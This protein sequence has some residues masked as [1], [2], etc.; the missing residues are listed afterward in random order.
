MPVQV[1]TPYKE[2]TANGVTTVFPLEFDC[3]KSE[4][5][6]VSLDGNEASVGS[7]TLSG[8]SVVFNTAPANGVIVLLQRN[9]PY[10][11]TTNYQSYD[12]SFRPSPVNK[13]FDLIWWKLQELGVAD[14]ILGNRINALKNYVDERDDELRAYLMEEIRKQGVAL[15]QLEE[16]YNY[17][18]ER[19]A[20]I[21]V[22]RGW[23]S[24][25]V[26]HRGKT[27]YEIN[28]QNTRG[29]KNIDEL[30]EFT[31]S[32][33]SQRV[34]TLEYHPGSG[35]GGALYIWDSA[36]NEDDDGCFIIAVS[37]V[38]TGRWKLQ[39]LNRTLHATQAGLIANL[40]QTD[41][42]NQSSIVQK[43][44][45]HIAKI[46]GGIVKLP[47]GHIYA[48]VLAKSNV[49]IQGTFESF[50]TNK[51]YAEISANPTGVVQ[52]I[53]YEHGT[54]WHSTGSTDLF[55]M[56]ENVS[57]CRISNLKMLGLR[58][59][60]SESACGFGMRIIGD[61]FSAKY[62]DTSGFRFEGL[63]IRGK[64]GVDC[65]NHY[66]E[67]CNFDDARRNTAALVFCHDVHFKNCKFRQLKPEL[68]WVYLFDIEPNP[69]TSDTV[70]NVTMENCEFNAVSSS[71]AEPTV[72]VKEQNTPTGSPNVKFLNCRFK[73]VATIRN[74]CANGWKDCIVD[75]CEF[76]TYAFSTTLGYTI[77]SG[78]FTNN[79]MYGLAAKGFSFNTPATGDFIIE[80]NIFNDTVFTSN[81]LTSQASFGLNTFTGTA[82][83]VAPIDRRSITAQ[84]RITP[85]V[86]E[87]VNPVGAAL[88]A[89]NHIEVRQ[90][91]LSTTLTG[92]LTARLRSGVKIT[93]TGCDA[94]DSIG[95]KAFVELFINSDN[96]T[97]VTAAQ[98]ILNPATYGITFAWNERTL[99][100]ASKSTAA[101]QFIIKV[102][103]FAALP[104][105]KDVAW[106]V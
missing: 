57:N 27:Q 95:S 94:N 55:Y 69:S 36:S 18:M 67:N 29:I 99:Q 7:W 100:L 51:T 45:D 30:R 22:D 63:Y 26:V 87:V 56:P 19:L 3:D 33:S 40:A 103:V 102:E 62:V 101:N 89:Y 6:I 58:F 60:Q 54:F 16:Y 76:D 81:I 83:L 59:D 77:L 97:S 84:Y 75:N 12:N 88:T 9:T 1:Q 49:E 92:I 13:D 82:T 25:F 41:L 20:Q 93:I 104:Q 78:K 34:Q 47:K 31:G 52:A 37:G 73:G 106:L 65:G 91:N 14:W 8:E 96:L 46:G 72:L 53:R 4:Y 43:C 10:Q 28:E 24:S 48:Q 44:I 98:E 38:G 42:I 64:V 2:Y 90:I 39:L 85:S 21:A 17:L 66:F 70:Y 15:D 71:G 50:V 23:D 68:S 105:Y 11:R 35:Y 5:L 80:N 79:R 32:F 74:N 86:L 61:S